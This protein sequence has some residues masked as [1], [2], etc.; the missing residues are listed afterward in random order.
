[1][2]ISEISGYDF[3]N[4]PWK[5]ILLNS[6]N[7][8]EINNCAPTSE[9]CCHQD[10]QVNAGTIKISEKC[11]SVVPHQEND[12]EGGGI[13][14]SKSRTGNFNVSHFFYGHTKIS[15]FLLNIPYQKGILQNPGG[16]MSRPQIVAMNKITMIVMRWAFLWTVLSPPIEISLPHSTQNKIQFSSFADQLT[17]EGI[18][19]L[20][21]NGATHL[22]ITRQ[23]NV[24]Y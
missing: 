17:Y 24:R 20:A 8:F 21:H 16:E 22:C 15:F 9:T 7:G 1:M 19:N 5:A 13:S 2:C 10:R 4:L 6:A 18:Y 12:E 23:K 3:Y 11:S 14:F